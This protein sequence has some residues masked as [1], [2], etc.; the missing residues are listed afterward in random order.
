MKT[1]V[2]DTIGG[3]PVSLSDARYQVGLA[4]SDKDHDVALR[5]MLKAAIE[6]AEGHTRMRVQHQRVLFTFDAFPDQLPIYPVRE[7]E[8]IVYDTD[9]ADDVSLDLGSVYLDLAGM[10][11]KLCPVDEWPDLKSGKPGSVRITAEVGAEAVPE[12]F[13]AAVLLR[14]KEQF[15]M[16][17]ESVIGAAVSPSQLTFEALLHRYVRY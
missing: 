17:G 10:Y 3:L 2:V 5:S 1:T 12:D 11:P 6:S 7:I 8:S 14:T 4:D 13:K 9:D 15:A 16:R